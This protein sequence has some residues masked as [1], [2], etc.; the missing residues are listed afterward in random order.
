[1]KI[2]TAT[3]TGLALAYAVSLAGGHTNPL[4]S[5][6]PEPGDPEYVAGEDYSKSFYISHP[7]PRHRMGP[8]MPHERWEQ[9]GPIIDQDVIGFRTMDGKTWTADSFLTS[10]QAAGPTH[11]VSAMRCFVLGRLGEEVDIPEQVL[12]ASPEAPEFA[13]R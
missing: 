3:L 2:K 10:A 6:A 5:F 11:L 1:M 7:D 9:G 12:R 8:F 4:Y 13:R